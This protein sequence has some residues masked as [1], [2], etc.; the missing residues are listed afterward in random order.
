MCVHTHGGLFFRA[1]YVIFLAVLEI[2]NMTVLWK[3]ILMLVVWAFAKALGAFSKEILPVE[4]SEGISDR[5]KE[6]FLT[7]WVKRNL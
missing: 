7:N 5:E 1:T 2:K 3:K 6:I 4:I